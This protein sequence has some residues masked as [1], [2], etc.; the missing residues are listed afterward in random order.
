MRSRSETPFREVKR[1]AGSGRDLRSRSRGERARGARAAA[2]KLLELQAWVRDKL[3]R[4]HR[5][6]EDGRLRSSIHALI[7][8]LDP[9]TNPRLRWT[10]EDLEHPE[11]APER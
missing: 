7:R 9:E 5:R 3:E 10:L 11:S 4:L 8:A 6:L 2:A 1:R